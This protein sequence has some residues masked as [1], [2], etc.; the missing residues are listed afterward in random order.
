MQR[1]PAQTVRRKIR[2]DQYRHPWVGK[3]DAYQSGRLAYGQASDQGGYE[4]R[5]T[6]LYQSKAAW[7]GMRARAEASPPAR[8][9]MAS[10]T[11]LILRTYGPASAPRTSPRQPPATLDAQ[12]LARLQPSDQYASNE[13]SAV[14]ARRNSACRPWAL[15]RARPRPRPRHRACV[16]HR[17]A[18]PP[19]AATKT[20]AQTGILEPRSVR[21]ELDLKRTLPDNTDRSIAYLERRFNSGAAKYSTE[22]NLLAIHPRMFCNTLTGSAPFHERLPLPPPIL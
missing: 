13:R 4:K 14:L 7:R 21:L 19:T 15:C 8:A 18:T 3:P 22:V 16:T 5:A 1:W 17:R 10:K 20:T 9:R 2:S 6:E 12:E 11:T